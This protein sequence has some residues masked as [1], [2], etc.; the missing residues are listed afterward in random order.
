MVGAA[1]RESLRLLSATRKEPEVESLKH[2]LHE[3]NV[4][5]DN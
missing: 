5:R 4:L 3:F 1:I 2:H